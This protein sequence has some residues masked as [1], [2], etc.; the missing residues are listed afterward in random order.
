[1][2]HKQDSSLRR[3][4]ALANQGAA[5]VR[6][7]DSASTRVTKSGSSE[8]QSTAQIG[9]TQEPHQYASAEFLPRDEVDEEGGNYPPRSSTN[10]DRKGPT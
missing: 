1:M 8:Y 3:Q 4:A 2:V 9:R 7:E 6:V 10:V 5:I